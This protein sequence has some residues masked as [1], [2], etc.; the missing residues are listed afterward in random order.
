MAAAS[1]CGA[2]FFALGIQYLL[3]YS[4]SSYLPIPAA[5]TI[6]IGIGALTLVRDRGILWMNSSPG[7]A[8]EEAWW[9]TAYWVRRFGFKES[10]LAVPVSGEVQIAHGFDEPPSHTGLYRHAL[11][12]QR[13][14]VAVE[15]DQPSSLWGAA[16]T[17]PA[18]GFVE[19]LTNHL[20]DNPPGGGRDSEHWG[21]HVVI[22]LDQGAWLTLAHLQQGSV[23]VSQGM[24]VETGTYIAR[25]GS[26]GRSAVAHLHLHVQS[27]P[28][29]G[30]A[31]I[32]FRLAN[33]QSVVQ[34]ESPSVHWHAAS[35]PHMGDIIMAAPPNPASHSVLTSMVPGCAVWNLHTEG[36]VPREFRAA[37]LKQ[38]FKLEITLDEQGCQVFGKGDEGEMVCALA[39]DAWRVIALRKTPS[40]FL[41]LLATGVPSIPYAVT[42]GMRWDDPVPMR[43]VAGW[44][45]VSAPY[46]KQPF[47]IASCTC[48]SKPGGNRQVITIAT[49]LRSHSDRIPSSIECEFEF[50]R[51][52]VKLR[53]QFE[54]G[55]IS[56]SL[57]SFAPEMPP[58]T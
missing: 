35:V 12:L 41:R 21:N 43:P 7:L 4:A 54:G 36:R 44:Q 45:L 19:R 39:P 57:V 33:F 47:Q 20:P 17:A 42:P 55:L 11:D 40:S 16:V 37:R 34:S 32:P 13:P 58:D 2:S 31:T 48:L 14:L 25:V 15:G 56:Y 53:A 28:T 46:R 51:G 49:R 8:P 27:S 29:P 24:R 9:D 10:L 6:W 18:P 5:L 1:G 23:A 38:E 52:P 30:S 26:S 50:L 22:R 3:Q